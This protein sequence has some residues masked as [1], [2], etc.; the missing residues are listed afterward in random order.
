MKRGA[1]ERER[2]ATKRA[3][4]KT[5]VSA[6]G[7]ESVT[8]RA[9]GRGKLKRHA[10]EFG[11][12][13][14]SETDTIPANIGREIVKE[15]GGTGDCEYRAAGLAD[16]TAARDFLL[17]SSSDPRCVRQIRFALKSL[18]GLRACEI[19]A[20]IVRR[21]S[22]SGLAELPGTGLVSFQVDGRTEAI[23]DLINWIR[24]KTSC[25]TRGGL[26]LFTFDQTVEIV[27]RGS[28]S[29]TDPVGKMQ[30]RTGEARTTDDAARIQ[31]ERHQASVS[32]R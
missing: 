26:P 25:H 16:R 27:S 11:Q 18:P 24:N 6:L 20:D 3:D 22:V 8:F 12:A 5:D 9:D 29:A 7:A 23:A 21:G 30:R 13:E 31:I 4:R 17:V 2:T 1:K 28:D 15:A 19:G 10:R 14:L 32:A